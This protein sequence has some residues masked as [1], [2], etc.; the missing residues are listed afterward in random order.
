MQREPE[1]R[2]DD[3]PSLLQAVLDALARRPRGGDAL[4]YKA[5]VEVDLP[6]ALDAHAPAGF[7][8]RGRTGV[9]D[10]ADVPWLGLFPVDGAS[11]K[12]GVYSVLLFAADGSAVY[13]SLNQGTEGVRGGTSVLRKRAI[14][15]RDVI[16]D[17]PDLHHVIDLASPAERPRRYEAANALARVYERGSIPEAAEIVDD[18]HRFAR[19]GEAA[20]SAL[21][22]LG[23]VEPVHV[24]MKWNAEIR[25]DTLVAHR[26]VAEEHGQVWWGKFGKSTTSP[27]SD[28]R[29][30]TL[31][32][33]LSDSPTPTRC[34][35]YRRGEVWS[36][37]LLDITR[38]PRSV[39]SRLLPSYYGVEDCNLFLLLSDFEE[40]PDTWLAENALME[41]NPDPAGIAGALGNQTS[42][43]V[44]YTRAAAAPASSPSLP[45]RR[46][47]P[48]TLEVPDLDWLERQ[49]LWPRE[50][51]KELVETLSER[52]QII[53]AGPPGTGK[54]WV[55]KHVARYVTRDT[56]LAYKVLQFHP[57]YGYE[58]FIEALRPDP[59][60]GGLSFTRTDG[61]VLRMVA[62][63]NEAVDHPYVLILDEMNRANLPRVFGELMYALEYRDEPTELLYTPDFALPN[64]L[65][66]VGTMNTADRSIRSLD[67]A[68]RRRFDIFECPPDRDI[69]SRYYEM[70]ENQVDGLIDGFDALND[71]LTGL[72]DR[73]HTIGHTFFMAPEFTHSRLERVWSRQLRPL[74]DEYLFDQPTAA[75]GFELEEFW[76]R[77][78]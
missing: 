32:E 71:R 43:L 47:K 5:L 60:S 65:Q 72:L 54:T 1:S 18:I 26:A 67:V 25:A 6:A 38:D 46:M 69:L 17:Q 12:T 31:K 73:H 39:E 2:G 37:R 53:L 40:V 29:L 58:D 35:L 70:N 44:I 42:P 15:I 14:D 41:R 28:A 7:T 77:A 48:G 11:A 52:P 64:S 66:F 63:M 56:S 9:G 75:D 20:R 4:E 62:S 61:A 27:I 36:A 78:A 51:L 8:F 19:M 16:G 34:Y 22:N 68:L 74:I 59:S 57:S 50:H 55:A 33:Q 13:L 23:P 76:P 3:V 49:T 24:V 30:A 45:P 10:T 21:G